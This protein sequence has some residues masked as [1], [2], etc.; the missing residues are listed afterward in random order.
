MSAS[1][2]AVRWSELRPDEFRTRRDACP[3]VYLPLGLCEPHGAVAA[4]GLDLL[5][6]EHYCMEAARRFGGIVAPSQGYHIHECGFHAPWLAATVGEADPLLTAVPP[7]VMLR[8]FLYQLRAFAHAGFAAVIGVSGH[9][10]GSQED[11]RRA[12]AIFARATGVRVVVKTDPEWVAGLHAGD[13]A[14]KY[15]LSQLVALRPELVDLTLIPRELARGSGERFSL[16]ADAAEAS[17][18]HGR[19]INEAVVAAIG[20][21]VRGLAVRP[22]GAPA[23]IRLDYAAVEALWTELAAAMAEWR[24]LS[25]AP[26]QTAVPSPSQWHGYD[27]ALEVL[28]GA[29]T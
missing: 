13:H 1:D 3:I 22:A 14:G 8:L 15:E 29:S 24:S 5:K 25:L 19:A 26:N 27:R 4:L 16:G 17:A 10:G 2:P 11:L 21:E 23:R 9:A 18:D 7:H 12:G 20:A 6:A 28:R